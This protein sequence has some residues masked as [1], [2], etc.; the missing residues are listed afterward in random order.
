MFGFESSAEG[1]NQISQIWTE[2]WKFAISANT[3]NIIG[4]AAWLVYLVVMIGRFGAT[5]GKMA[6]G[7]KVVRE[8]LNPVSYGIAF[9]REILIKSILFIIIFFISWLGYLWITWDNKK[10]GWHDK[11]ARTLVIVG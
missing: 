1:L 11:I 9:V 4:G 10:Q 6:V 8:D 5:L 7:I 3:V 2:I